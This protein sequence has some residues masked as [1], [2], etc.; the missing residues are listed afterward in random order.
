MGGPWPGR[1]SRLHH[2]PRSPGP[3]V[4]LLRTPRNLV[5]F[6]LPGPSAMQSYWVFVAGDTLVRGLQDRGQGWDWGLWLLLNPPWIS[7]DDPAPRPC[8]VPASQVP[9]LPEYVSVTGHLT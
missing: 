2:G 1:P 9:T 8:P 5:S 6:D 3:Q 4:P 7:V